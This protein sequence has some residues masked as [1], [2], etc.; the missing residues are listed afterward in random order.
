VIDIS[1]IGRDVRVKG[2]NCTVVDGEA[3][4]M[5]VLVENYGMG[6]ELANFYSLL[7]HNNPTTVVFYS[8]NTSLLRS[9][10]LFYC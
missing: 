4:K 10:Y 3:G 8:P 9:L 6:A 2:R 5:K 7:E 1:K